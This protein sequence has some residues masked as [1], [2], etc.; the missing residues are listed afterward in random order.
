MTAFLGIQV[1]KADNSLGSDRFG[2]SYYQDQKGVYT[3]V[4]GAFIGEGERRGANSLGGIIY[5]AKGRKFGIINSNNKSVYGL[6]GIT[7]KIARLNNI[8]DADIIQIGSRIY[9]NK[10]P[11]VNTTKLF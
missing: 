6:G 1:A 2:H 8:P 4:A 5:G 7:R 10:E 9:I 3:E 11:L